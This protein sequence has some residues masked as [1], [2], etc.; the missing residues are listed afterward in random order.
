MSMQQPE[1]R[2]KPPTGTQLWTVAFPF[3]IGGGTFALGGVGPGLFG[4]VIGALAVVLAA[5]INIGS[6]APAHGQAD[7]RAN[8]ARAQFRRWWLVS[9]VAV[10]VGVPAAY[11]SGGA[12]SG[13]IALV[14][15]VLIVVG[16]AA[17]LAVM[18][19]GGRGP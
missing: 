4:F 15:A 14:A 18:R 5:R 11:L 19:S 6:P 17:A 7:T 3:I 9:L 1:M 16:G 2:R 8:D 12:A 13:T 10:A